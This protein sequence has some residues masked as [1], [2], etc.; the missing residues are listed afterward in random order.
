MIGFE[1]VGLMPDVYAIDLAPAP[2]AA[3]MAAL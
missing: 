3:S 1:C 2:A